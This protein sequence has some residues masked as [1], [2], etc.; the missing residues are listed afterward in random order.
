MPHAA[1]WVVQPSTPL[2]ARA[3]YWF[4]CRTRLCGWCNLYEDKFYPMQDF[5]FNAARG[6]AGGAALLSFRPRWHDLVSMPHAALWVVQPTEGLVGT[7]AVEVSMPH[8]ALWV[9]QLSHRRTRCGHCC[10]SM[11]HAALWVVQPHPPH[12]E[13]H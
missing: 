6:F 10:V 4:Q 3:T 11:P 5:G 8:A 2:Y 9:V 1:L 13:H 12:G 7:K